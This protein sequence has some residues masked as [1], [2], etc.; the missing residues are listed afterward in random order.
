[1]RYAHGTE[2]GETAAI[3]TRNAANH[4]IL[5]KVGFFRRD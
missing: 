3:D 1:M 4:P 5:Q 2:V